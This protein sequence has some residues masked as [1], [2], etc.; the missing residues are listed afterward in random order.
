MRAEYGLGRTFGC[1][2]NGIFPSPGRTYK[3]S[4]TTAIKIHGHVSLSSCCRRHALGE[5]Q[6]KLKSALLT[7]HV[8]FSFP[9]Y[10]PLDL[11][12]QVVG[13]PSVDR[14]V[15]N[16]LRVPGTRLPPPS[17]ASEVEGCRLGSCQRSLAVLLPTSQGTPPATPFRYL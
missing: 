3:H 15:P 7:H 10:Q 16:G 17:V 11:L 1:E 12:V 6:L 13:R 2:S 14:E 8:P 4:T 5:E 9:A